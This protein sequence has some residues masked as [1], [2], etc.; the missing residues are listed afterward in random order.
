MTS[1][2]FISFADAV[3]AITDDYSKYIITN[4]LLDIL[5]AFNTKFDKAKFVNYI[6]K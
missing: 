6:N 2:Q 3:K 5:P 4:F 1:K